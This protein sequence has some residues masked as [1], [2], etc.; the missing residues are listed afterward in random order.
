MRLV[1]SNLLVCGG[2][3]SAPPPEQG[4]SFVC[5]AVPP[6]TSFLQ[7]RLEVSNY[8]LKV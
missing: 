3:S 6:C 2:D 8:Y 4:C 7:E 5:W 1:F